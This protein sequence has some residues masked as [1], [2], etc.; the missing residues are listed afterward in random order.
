MA[1]VGE[2]SYVEEARREKRAKLEA[3]GVAPFAYRYARTHTAAEAL[4]AYDPAMG[5]DRCAFDP[6]DFD[7]LSRNERA[8][9]LGDARSLAQR[10]LYQGRQQKLAHELLSRIDRVAK[11]VT[12]P[13]SSAT[14]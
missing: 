3:M 5:D 1:D 10:A 8:R 2:R 4:A 14:N 7:Q 6:G 9:E 12:S 13:P 11:T